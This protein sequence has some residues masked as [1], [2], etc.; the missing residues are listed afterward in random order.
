MIIISSDKQ[1]IDQWQHVSG[2]VA[3]VTATVDGLKKLLSQ[4]EKVCLVDLS[5]LDDTQKAELEKLI[6]DNRQVGFFIFVAVPDEMEGVR[7]IRAGAKGYANRL[8]NEAIMEAALSSMQDG[9]IWASKQVVQYLLRRLQEVGLTG[10]VTGLS[11][12]TEREH[13]IADAVGQGLNNKEIAEKC[14]ISERTVKVHLNKVFKK[15]NVNSRVQLAL[16]LE[17][18]KA[19]KAQILYN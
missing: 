15:M 12:L 17:K 11:L 1:R 19:E 6:A 14:D 8:M 10:S 5:G 13:E 16:E 2:V 4:A 7:W 3:K 18:A 9:D